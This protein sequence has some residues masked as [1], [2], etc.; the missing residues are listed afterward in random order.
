M[1]LVDVE[2]LERRA[3]ADDVDDGVEPADLVE[4]DLLGRPA[5]QASFGAASASNVASARTP[6]PIG[7]ARLFDQAGDVPRGAH[8]RGLLGVHVDVRRADA[9]AQDR[10]G[11][12]RPPADRDA[13]ADRA[14]LV[15]VGARVDEAPS[16]MS[17]A[18]PEKQWNQ[19]TLVT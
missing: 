1:H 17:P 11:L 19:A 4:V 8:D 3:G 13:A 5:V 9:A 15:E 10:L 2:H 14:H 7:K 6:H 12:E 16:A 18:M